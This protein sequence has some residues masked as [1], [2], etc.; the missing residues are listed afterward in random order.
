MQ[1]KKKLKFEKAAAARKTAAFTT[2]AMAPIKRAAE[3]DASNARTSKHSNDHRAAKRPKTEE[4]PVS[5]KSKTSKFAHVKEEETPTKEKPLPVRSSILKTEDKAFPRGGASV[6]TPLEHKQIQIQAT[7]DVLFEQ[8]GSKRPVHASGSEDEGES[9][10]ADEHKKTKKRKKGKDARSAVP[11]SKERIEKIEGLSYKRLVSG[12]LVLGQITQVTSRD[13]TL[14]LP[15]NLIGHVPLTAISDQLTKRVEKLL[16]ADED[17][18]MDEEEEEFE[19]IDPKKL[20]QVGQYL[21][22]YVMSNGSDENKKRIELSLDPRLV[23]KGLAKSDVAVDSMIQASVVS[24]EDHGLVMDLGLEDPTVKGFMGSKELG[25]ILKAEEIEEG[26]VFL[27]LVTGLNESGT[28]VKLSAD[29]NKAGN[30]KK[31]H[32]VKDAP[33]VNAFLPGTATE[34]LITDVT[35]FGIRGKVMG[36]L[37]VM[38]DL[39]HSGGAQGDKDIDEKYKIGSKVRARIIFSFPKGESQKIG[40]STLEHV[41]TLGPR[42]LA[43]ARGVSPL[44]QLPLSTIVDEAKVT[45]VEASIGLYLDVGVPRVPAFAHISRLS[46]KKIDVLSQ[47]E[48]PY[49]LKSVH[50]ARVVGYNPVDGL[51]LV[52]LEQKVLDQPFLRIADIK[53]GEVIKGT[54]EKLIVNERGVG[55][56]LVNLADGISGLVTEMHMADVHLEHPDR[57]FKEGMKVTTRVL[58]TNPEKRLIRLTLKKSLVN[59]EV[60]P[61]TDMSKINVGDQAPGTLVSIIEHGAI[62][63]FYGDVQAFLPVAEMSEA[64]IKDPKEHFRVGQV[65]NV[66]VLDINRDTGK[67]RV[68]CKDP[69]IFGQKQL[70]AY[71]EV[72]IGTLVRGTITEISTDVIN[73]DLKSGVKGVLKLAHLADKSEKRCTTVLKGLRVGQKMK[74]LLVLEKQ[75]KQ[76]RLVFSNKVSLIQAAAAGELLSSIGDV[77][78]GVKVAGFIRNIASAGVFVQFAA[79]LVGLL[80]ASGLPDDVKLRRAEDFDMWIGQSISATVL[81]VDIANQRMVLT[82]REDQIEAREAKAKSASSAPPPPAD[83]NLINPV[84]KVSKTIH[85]FTVGKKTVARLRKI[86]P[87]QMNIF[88][89]D[90]VQGRIHISSMFKDFDSIPNPKHPLAHLKLQET[91]PVKIIGLHEAKTQKFLPLSHRNAMH[92]VFECSAKDVDENVEHLT[93][94]KLKIG[95]EKVAFVTSYPGGFVCAHLAPNITGFIDILDFVGDSTTVKEEYPLGS[96]LRV[97]IKSVDLAQNRVYVVPVSSNKPRPTSLKEL[98]VGSIHTG[99]IVKVTER[100]VLVKLSDEVAGHVQLT[101]FSDAYEK[102][103]PTTFNMN[104]VVRVYV[105]HVDVS[106][107]RLTFSMRPSLISPKATNAT[108][109]DRYIGSYSDIKPND[110]VRGFIRSILDVGLIVELG[111]GVQALVGVAEIS[112]KFI[113]NWKEGFELDQLVTGKVIHV[114]TGAKRSNMSLKGSVLSNKDWQPDMSWED[115]KD[116][117]IVSGVVVKVMDY[118]VFILISNSRNIRGLCHKSEMADNKVADVSKLYE[119][120]DKVKAKIIKI[121]KGKQKKVNFSLKASHFTETAKELVDSDGEE[122]GVN[123]DVDS[124]EEME[125]GGDD[126]GEVKDMVDGESDAD[127]GASGMSVDESSPVSKI[128]KGLST[129]GFDW[130]GSLDQDPNAGYESDASQAA[131]KKKKRRKAEIQVDKTGDLDKN[132]PQSTADFER[133]L[134]GQPN[135]S[136]L[137]IQYMA[138]QLSLSEVDK[139]R[140]LAERAL[141]TIHMREEEQKLNVWVAWLNLENAYGTEE[142]L[143]AVFEKACQHGDKKEM[144]ERL[145]SIYIDSGKHK[146]TRIT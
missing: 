115:L 94:E 76:H 85:D 44:E 73:I 77:K 9:A 11:E 40:V 99:R 38:A 111:P 12:S 4:K 17:V 2:A 132:G 137:W 125:N 134:L 89:A 131:I 45:K 65:V 123:I 146:V 107:K 35:N 101:E 5:K 52:S 57:K 110:V 74:D 49:K 79:G 90:N 96:A 29:H 102:A 75:E 10:F 36:L 6:L 37:D 114:D 3:T 136:S 34:L 97:R 130:S 32:L 16:E 84:D 39:L 61:W 33:T 25:G 24:V 121:D 67:M 78:E 48:G 95:E 82:L 68:S 117:Q 30:L 124:D 18:K 41:L 145:A 23:N 143:E 53:V 20:F 42:T 22:A 122:G 31:L 7:E 14:A 141:R 28:I 50:K 105:G 51:F 118:G 46:D 120:G 109:K 93:I 106:T 133:Q 27:C 108:V 81:S 15:N 19:D 71:D 144:Y 86:Y 1:A 87:A 63:H 119:E 98:E 126:F 54:V 127:E 60:E 83:N 139:A 56:V 59:S 66:H 112:D 135:S 69:A 104:D 72:K 70:D 128:V 103:N 116:G 62:V 26:T 91:L 113:K 47:T 8:A 92:S 100:D 21:R 142:S 13:L 140:E 58:S 138:F 88:L 80:P 129:N 55:G 64:Y 43:N